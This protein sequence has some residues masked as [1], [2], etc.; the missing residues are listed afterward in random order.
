MNGDGKVTS[1]DALAILRM[2]VKVP[3][4][5]TPA[6]SFVAETLDLWD[7]TAG[8]SALHRNGVQWNA[9]LTGTPGPEQRLNLVAVLRGD[10]NGSWSSAGAQDLDVVDPNY[11]KLLGS[12]LGQPLDVWGG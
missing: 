12:Q 5:P 9:A 3:G 6:W 8:A 10:V 2:A 7:E 1:T 4:A 11:F